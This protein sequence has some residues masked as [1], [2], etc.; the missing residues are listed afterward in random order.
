M[1]YK[2]TCGVNIALWEGTVVKF[3]KSHIVYERNYHIFI[4]VYL[5]LIII[6]CF[7]SCSFQIYLYFKFKDSY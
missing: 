3:R 2:K 5:I 6:V 4:I 7:D 1:L